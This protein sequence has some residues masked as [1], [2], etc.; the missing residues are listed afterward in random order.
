MSNVRIALGLGA[1]GGG[2]WPAMSV[3]AMRNGT[4]MKNDCTWMANFD[5]NQLR[6]VSPKVKGHHE[7][8]PGAYAYNGSVANKA[9]ELGMDR[10]E[11][12]GPNEFE[13]MSDEELEAFLRESDC[14][15]RRLA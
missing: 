8:A 7:E 2:T 15:G 12:G 3:E 1:R 14:P 4:T 10:N 11:V 13:R 9:L 5:C 6:T